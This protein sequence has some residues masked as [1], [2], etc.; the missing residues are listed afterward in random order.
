MIEFNEAEY[1]RGKEVLVSVHD[2]RRTFW[3]GGMRDR[4]YSEF[5]CP[6]A[7]REQKRFSFRLRL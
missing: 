7:F 6:P 1:A 3:R 2:V 4:T 5:H